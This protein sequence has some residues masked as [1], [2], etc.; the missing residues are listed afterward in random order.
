M[1]KLFSL[2]AVLTLLAALVVPSA[3]AEEPVTIEFW[4]SF[5]Q[6]LTD[7]IIP[8]IAEFEAANP[9]IKVNPVYAGSYGT[10]N[11]KLLAAH[12]ANAVPAVQQ[13][14]LTSVATFAEN[15]VIEPIDRFIEASGDDMSVYAEGMYSAFSYNGQQYGVPAFHSVC[16][17][18]YYNK[19]FATNEGIEMPKT[20]DEFDA[21]LRKATIK[22]ENG[23]TV[24]YGCALAG[25]STSYFAPIFWANGV[26]AFEDEEMTISGLGSDK[27]VEII[28]MIKGWVDEGLVKWYYGTNA[29]T[30]MRQSLID[31]SSFS[32]FHT[33][34]VYSVYQPG[35]ANNGYELGVAFSPAGEGGKYVA[36][37][38]GSG[39]TIMAKATEEQKQAAYKFI[40]WMSS[41]EANMIIIKA[42]GYMPVT[43]ECLESDACKEWVANNPELQNLY[44][45]MNDI[46]AAPSSPVWSDIKS[47]WQDGLAQI[48]IEGVDVET[49]VENMMD[50]IN[51]ILA[52]M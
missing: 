45:H 42:T 36:D 2:L 17:T 40:R 35:L 38:G 31:G 44:D 28:K 25:W 1:K 18:F 52:D 26:V 21:F 47:K 9:G 8:F 30:N 48:F 32:V 27:A 13:T 6:Q 20:W 3:I 16:P 24:R 4:Y 29:S 34:G 11:Q 43:T 41:P 49:G 39:L 23:N 15:G 50:A 12:A 37:L 46:V 5:E 10:S 14:Q 19:T 51:E 33:S 22:D 7:E